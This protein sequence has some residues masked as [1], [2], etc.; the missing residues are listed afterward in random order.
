[1]GNIYRDII[2]VQYVVLSYEI[3]T[4]KF[5]AL[6]QMMKSCNVMKNYTFCELCETEGMTTGF[7]QP[8]LDQF[9]RIFPS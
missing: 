4:I 5:T 3:E 6:M 8:F 7:V 1:M 9:M 2:F